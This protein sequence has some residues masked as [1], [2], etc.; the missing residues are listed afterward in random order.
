M[1]TLTAEDGS[2]NTHSATATV[3][4]VDNIDPVAVAQDITVALDANGAASITT[5]DIDNG[6]S[7]NCSY[8][9]SLDI[10][11]FDCDD[12]G[13]NVVTLTAEDGSGNTHSA[14]ATVTVVDNIDPVAVAQDIT[15]ALDAN[16]AASITTADIDNG[17][18]DNC[19]YSLSLD[20]TSFDCDDLGANVVTLTAEDGSGN[21]HS[22][23]ATVTVVD[24]IDPVAVAQDITVAL[25]AN[26]AAS[27]TTADI[28]NGSSDNCS[29]SLSLDITSFDCD[30][31]GAN[32]V[33]LT[34][35]DGSGNTHSAT[36]TVT[37]VDNID[38]VAVAQDITVALDA[39]GAASITTAD[40][41][42]GSSDNCSYSLSLD[43]TSFDC[44]DLGANVVTLTA[45]DGSGNTHSA[46]ATVTVVDNID[47]VAVAQDITVALDASGAA[48]ITTADID[49]GSSDNCS[50][51]LSLDIT[52]F[53]CDDLGAN[54]VTLTA[55]DGSGNTHSATATV[56]VVDNIDPVAVAQD[57][58]VA[59]DA[60]GAASIT[61]ADIDNGSSDNCSYSLSLDITSFDCDDLGA[62]VVTLTAED[63]SGNTHSATATVTVVDNIDPVAVAQDITVA[64]DANGAASITTA[65]IDN[66]SSDNCSYSLSLDITSF[67]CD[68]LGA[69]VVTLTAEDGS[70][71]THSATATVTVV[72]N[73]DPVAVA[74]DIT[75]AL[76]ANGAASI[77]TADIDNGSS[78][79]CSY[80]LSLDITSF[81][82]DDL[83]ANV[84]TLTAEDGSGNTHSA[85]ATVTVVDNIDPVAVAQDITV[86]LDASGAASITTADIDNGSSDNCSY[87]LSLDITSFDCD[88]LGANVVTLTAE[89]G[90]GN[91]HSATATV[92]VVDNIDPVAVAQDITVALDASGAAS[93][94][95]ADIDNGSSDN[96][97][98]S[99][100]LDITSFDCDDLGANVVTLTAEDGS[101]NTHS[102]TATVT[103]V[104]NIDPVAVAQDITVALDA[105]G[106]ASITTADIDNGSSDNCSYSLSLD[107]TSFDCDD[108]GANVVTLT[109]EDGSGNTHSATATVTVV[110]NI[111]PVEVAQDITVAWMLLV[112]RASLRQTSITEVA[113]TVRTV[114]L[115]YYL[116]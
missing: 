23:T 28:D 87:S 92:T 42:N 50:Y 68:D 6:S 57:I 3:T 56:T 85:T 107:I 39:N 66:G 114:Y 90:S 64:L 104:D 51:S 100:S 96:C 36:A 60:N 55:E 38:P 106:A 45:E 63:G 62:N 32:V 17:S 26:G 14:T 30:D 65:D 12:L 15:V 72:D 102:A 98:Y 20:I 116:V 73:I 44:D 76:D 115:R 54:V 81:D 88:D 86:A 108:L 43:I 41:D 35:E 21:T 1:V 19:S 18:S 77:T 83:G 80:S 10:T 74:Q 16:G 33:T 71:N 4:V 112:L 101:G 61:T 37:V 95:T 46:T 25:D 58:T 69:N 67:D 105:N 5:A 82:C 109:A 89:D 34:A 11:S 79:N 9:L 7:D 8:S 93:I 111:D 59:L 103:V 113:T 2:G 22:A 78:D 27:I 47:P 52:S 97:S 31:L 13:A 53:D 110:D 99:L 48:S 24:N 40:I 91:T 49:N 70:G 84:V 94:T 75:V 29:Y